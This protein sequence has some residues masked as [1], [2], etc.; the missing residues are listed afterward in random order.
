MLCTESAE[1]SLSFLHSHLLH[2]QLLSM[3]KNKFKKINKKECHKE[4]YCKVYNRLVRQDP[5]E[6]LDMV[7]KSF[8]VEK[9]MENRGKGLV[10]CKFDTKQYN[11]TT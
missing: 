3:S 11:I 2:S 8:H 9:K 6:M 10:D 1:D 4:K 5:K 7:R